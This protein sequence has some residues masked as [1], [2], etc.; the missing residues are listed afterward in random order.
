MITLGVAAIDMLCCAFVS[1]ILLF[2]MFLLPQQAAG[3]DSAGTEDLLLVK[4]ALDSKTEVTLG[5]EMRPPQDEP[6]MIWPVEPS[7]VMDACARLSVSKDLANSCYFVLPSDPRS[8]YGMLV[9][10]QPKRGDWGIKIYSSDT[11]S[12][13]YAADAET[14]ALDIVVVGNEVYSYRTDGLK[15][16]QSVDLRNV[17]GDG[18]NLNALH[19]E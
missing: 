1:S 18:V 14:I 6:M 5:L 13:Y 4:W 7:S 11:T 8:L 2:V 15:P 3:S 16:G 10:E 9:I 19:I 17:K 12:H